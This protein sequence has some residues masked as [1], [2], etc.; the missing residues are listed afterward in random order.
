VNEGMTTLTGYSK[1]E[2][3]G[4]NVKHLATPPHSELHDLYME[5]Y[6]QTKKAHIVGKGPRQ[7]YMR[8]CDGYP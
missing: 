1:E 7:V 5:R 2:L 6:R 4:M 3:L 8:H